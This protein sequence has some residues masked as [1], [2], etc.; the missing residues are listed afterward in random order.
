MFYIRLTVYTS[1]GIHCME[2]HHS[3]S[4]WIYEYRVYISN[5][6]I[7]NFTVTRV[8]IITYVIIQFSLKEN[9]FY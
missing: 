3:L 1:D 5:L 4:R 2:V 7:V 6:F 9:L 8:H